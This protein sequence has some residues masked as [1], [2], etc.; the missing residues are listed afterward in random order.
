MTEALKDIPPSE[1]PEPE[2]G[3]VE[4]KV[5]SDSGL[6]PGPFCPPDHIQPML[7]V[8]GSEPTEYCNIHDRISMPDVTGMKESEALSLLEQLNLNVDT[9]EEFDDSVEP[10][11]V[12]D[13]D[14]APGSEL[15]AIDGKAPTVSIVIS[16]GPDPIRTVPD[17]VGM[18]EGDA[19]NTL[20][21]NRFEHIS[22]DYAFSD[23][24]PEGMV[25]EQ[26]PPAGSEANISDQITLVVSKGQE[27]VPVPD[28][29]G[30][31]EEEAM[32]VIQAAGLVP[33]VIHQPDPAQ[34]NTGVYLQDPPAGTPV[35]PGSTVT[36]TVNHE[37]A[38]PPPEPPT[39]EEPTTEQPTTEEPT[40]EQ[41]PPTEEPPTTEPSP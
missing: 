38:P 2:R 39:T 25:I 24:V 14:P 7:F 10:D 32:A 28:V 27:T 36:L 37:H 13:Q 20:K 4:V 18:S 12:I 34:T 21:S 17:V 31:S 26:R 5:C 15:V 19:I 9:S 11:I 35:L 1:F 40:T 22:V 16:K 33:N 29:L 23:T 30:K 8:E 6:L 3:L 41:P